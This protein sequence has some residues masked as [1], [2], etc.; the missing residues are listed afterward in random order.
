MLRPWPRASAHIAAKA[1]RHHK[2]C[3]DDNERHKG[4]QSQKMEAACALTSSKESGIP[5]EPRLDRRRLGSAG[6][7]QERSKQEDHSGIGKLLEGI[8]GTEYAS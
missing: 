1:C 8:I 7:N 5:R 6:Q 3:M 2:R 4:E